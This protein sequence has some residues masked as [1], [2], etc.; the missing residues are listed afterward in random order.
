MMKRTA[1]SKNVSTRQSKVA[2]GL[3]KKTVMAIGL[4]LVI[5]GLMM[6]PGSIGRAMLFILFGLLFIHSGLRSWQANDGVI[7]DLNWSG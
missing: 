7:Y 3:N 4:I 1:G 2:G 5:G 6:T